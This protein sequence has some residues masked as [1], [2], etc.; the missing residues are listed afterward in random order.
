M[1]ESSLR[2]EFSSQHAEG[3]TAV[4]IVVR[5]DLDFATARG[6]LDAVYAVAWD[7]VWHAYG[8]AGDALNQLVAV[9]VGDDPT[10][11]VAWTSLSV[12]ILHQGTVYEATVPAVPIIG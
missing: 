8:Q 2:K 6:I 11:D 12:E 5:E 1:I 3:K 9:V 7:E 10:R 4:P